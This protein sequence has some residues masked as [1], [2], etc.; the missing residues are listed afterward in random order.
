MIAVV[1]FYEKYKKRKT[2]KKDKLEE[3]P[4]TH[5]QVL[6]FSE[7]ETAKQ[8]SGVDMKGLV[9]DSISSIGK[10]EKTAK[11]EIPT[12]EGELIGLP[13]TTL[14]DSP[15]T[16]LKD[17]LGLVYLVEKPRWAWG[18]SII[19]LFRLHSGDR[20]QY[21]IYDH[22]LRER[23]IEEGDVIQTLTCKENRTRGGFKENI[24]A[25]WHKIQF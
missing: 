7:K 23:T 11:I 22:A 25:S 9:A 12:Y 17:S 6:R 14:I 3:S 4:F 10:D 19:S 16:R 1:N 21:R 18:D 15:N 24:L 8:Y 13:L 5:E 20:E 2:L